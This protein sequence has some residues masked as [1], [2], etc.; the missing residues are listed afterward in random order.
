MKV[1]I[2][3]ISKVPTMKQQ[4]FVMTYADLPTWRQLVMQVY[5]FEDVGIETHAGTLRPS[6][7]DTVVPNIE[8]IVYSKRHGFN[9]V[10]LFSVLFV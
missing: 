7:D 5:G 6:L 4:N 9:G 10:P 2:K 8:F 1:H 3:Q